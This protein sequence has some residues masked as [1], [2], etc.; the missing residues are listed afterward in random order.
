MSQTS[1]AAS[2]VS[3][4]AIA[5]EL[6]DLCR[7]GRNMEA[8]ERLYSPDIVSVESMGN[9]QM[10]AEMRGIDAIRG[11]NQWWFDNFEV[12]SAN[13]GGPFVGEDQFAVQH[14]YKTKEK[15]SGK[16]M[17]MTEMALYTVKNG[18]IVREEFFYN[19]NPK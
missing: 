18:K 7:E 12:I 15:A 11:K 5:H 17:D 8:I 16:E 9:E 2:G 3:T 6:T 13:V 10:P 14:Q 4:A 1:Q 19:P